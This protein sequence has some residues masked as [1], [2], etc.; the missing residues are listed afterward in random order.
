MSELFPAIVS[1]APPPPCKTPF[2]IAAVWKGRFWKLWNAE[3]ESPD[4]QKCVNELD[5]LR[6]NGWSH[7]TVLRLPNALWGAK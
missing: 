3:Y 6:A 5:R 1:L 2:F 4:C 7:I